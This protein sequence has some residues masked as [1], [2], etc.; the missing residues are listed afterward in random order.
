M[1][2]A[3]QE[4]HLV[5][6]T[7]LIEAGANVNQTNKDGATPLYW[8][9]VNGHCEIVQALLK[10]DADVNIARSDKGYNPLMAASHSGNV[11]IVM[12]LIE[13]GTD[14]NEINK[15]GGTA[16]DIAAQNGYKDIVK[17]LK[18]WKTSKIMKIMREQLKYMRHKNDETEKQLNEL[19]LQREESEKQLNDMKQHVQKAEQQMKQLVEPQLHENEK[20]KGEIEQLRLQVQ[21]AEERASCMEHELVMSKSRVI[22]ESRGQMMIQTNPDYLKSSWRVRRNEIEVL[23]GPALGVGGWGK[24]TV[25]MFRGTTVA[26]KFMHEAIVSQHNI[27]LF[28]REMNIAASVKI[29]RAHV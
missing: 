29:G 4:G 2:A 10:A 8:A 5:V 21:K 13:A 1:I 14:V 18:I 11:N 17:T 22:A 19:K 15:D 9:S 6:V 28:I 7:T 12:A 27:D 3:C 23:E 26:A 25:A 20:Q 24:V 16:L